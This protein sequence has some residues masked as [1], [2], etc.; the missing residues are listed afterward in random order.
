MNQAFDVHAKILHKGQYEIKQQQTEV[1]IKHFN[2]GVELERSIQY[3]IDGMNRE[4]AQLEDQLREKRRL[5]EE[6][7]DKI[8]E[9]A[10]DEAKKVLENAEQ[11]AFDRVQ[12]SVYEKEVMIQ[13]GSEEAERIKARASREAEDIKADAERDAAKIKDTAE[14]DGYESGVGEGAGR[15][16]RGS[17]FRRRQTP[18]NHRRNRP[19]T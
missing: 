19:R 15:R 8:I 1:P 2:A 7:A 16:A 14:K 11:H 13:Q 18:R 3:R 9:Q 6:Q 17:S 10:Q 4:I 12:K 5:N